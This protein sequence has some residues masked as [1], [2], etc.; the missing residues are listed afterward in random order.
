VPFAGFTAKSNRTK[1][2]KS[3]KFK[4]VFILCLPFMVPGTVFPGTV[5]A[6]TFAWDVDA[7]TAAGG[8]PGV[9]GSNHKAVTI[10]DA[11]Q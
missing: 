10:T 4:K 1:G 2:S 11:A 7:D 6:Y 5:S 8:N 9:Y 3:K